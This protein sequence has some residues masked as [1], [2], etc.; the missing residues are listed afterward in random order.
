M[1]KKINKEQFS[2]MLLT[3]FP[4]GVSGRMENWE[5]EYF[6]GWFH[7]N[8]KQRYSCIMEI[9]LDGEGMCIVFCVKYYDSDEL[10]IEEIDGYIRGIMRFL[11]PEMVCNDF[12]TSERNVLVYE[13]PKEND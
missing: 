12:Y 9:N 13:Y 10:T 2:K 1:K 7:I 11:A 4:Y 3:F 8:N 6:C 5:N